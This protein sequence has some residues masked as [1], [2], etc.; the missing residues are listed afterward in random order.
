MAVKKTRARKPSPVKSWSFSRYSDY[1]QCPFKFKLK[2]LDRI[3]EPPNDAM[4]RGAEIHDKAE[5]Y[6]K[7]TIKRIPKEL[8]Q[9]EDEIKRL[10]KIYKNRDEKPPFGEPP[11]IVVEDT[12]AFTREWDQTQWDNWVHCFVRIKL[13]CAVVEEDDVLV[14]TDWKTGKFRPDNINSYIEQLELYALAALLLYPSVKVIRPRLVYL[15]YGIIFPLEE[16]DPIEFTQK[17]LKKLRKT[18]AKRTKPMLTDQ[19]FK[20]QP[21]NFCRWCY[22]RADNK[23]NGGGQCKY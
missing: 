21:N 12:W 22:F 13:D 10:K 11:E 20:P 6:I 4:A 17:D 2:H 8:K 23:D 3:K 9:F 7:G 15:D 1:K 5:G 19:S 14:I 18:W 16:D